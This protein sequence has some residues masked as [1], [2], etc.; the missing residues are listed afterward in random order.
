ME[1]R[2]FE[3]CNAHGDKVCISNFGARLLQWHVSVEGKTRNIILG[4]PELTDYQTDPCYLGAF[5]GPYANRIGGAQ[6]S[7]DD[8]PFFIDANEGVNHLHGGKHS[9]SD[10]Y[11]QV[12]EQTE[13]SI[14]MQCDLADGF[15]GY[16]GAIQFKVVYRLNDER[17][18]IIDMYAVTE[19]STVIG[20]TSHPYFNL[21]GMGN[22]PQYHALQVSAQAYTEIDEQGISTGAILPVE[23][24]KLDFRQSRVLSAEPGQDAIDNNFV[25][26]ANINEPQAVLV[27]P[28]QKLRLQVSSTYPGVQIYTGD[29]LS[30][31]FLPREGICLEPQ[32]Y[33]NSPNIDAFPFCLT[34][35][36]EPFKAQIRYQ[37]VA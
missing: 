24:T 18:L 16:P 26:R 11:W 1:M 7:I 37:V 2:S 20:P 32:Y 10:L 21:A 14:T 15:N 8:T 3:L 33:P 22:A 31:A 36:Q 4:Y 25:V 28:D 34:T 29:F 23:G 17:A 19:Q 13:Q 27:S 35:P 6:F 5:V 12:V 9:V 30:G